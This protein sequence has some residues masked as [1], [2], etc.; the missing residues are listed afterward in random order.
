MQDTKIDILHFFLKKKLAGGRQ[1]EAGDN[2]R[3]GAGFVWRCKPREDAALLSSA[4][5]PAH[6]GM[7]AG[8]YPLTTPATLLLTCAATPCSIRC[9]NYYHP[10]C[11]V[12]ITS[13]K[14]LS[15]ALAMALYVCGQWDHRFASHVGGRRHPLRCGT[16]LC[17]RGMKACYSDTGSLWVLPL[18]LSPVLRTC[19]FPAPQP[20]YYYIRSSFFF[21]CW[22]DSQ[23]KSFAWAG[24]C[25]LHGLVACLYGGVLWEVMRAGP[26]RSAKPP[27]SNNFCSYYSNWFLGRPGQF[28]VGLSAERVPA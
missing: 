25:L 12:S 5:A 14:Y 10:S 28:T 7:A 8:T 15:C 26:A 27:L 2:A 17:W 3:Q 11:A 24:C 23:W 20:A 19:H 9:D 18:H 16:P 22:G 21:F 13:T 6:A 1:E 4:Q